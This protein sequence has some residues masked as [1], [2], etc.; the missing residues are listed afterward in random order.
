MSEANL[1]V[2]AAAVGHETRDADVNKLAIFGLVLAAM[3]LFGFV[4]TEAL[5]RYSIHAGNEHRHTSPFENARQIPPKP[6]LLVS[7]P[8]DYQ[9][10]MEHQTEMLNSY[11][12]VDPQQGTVRIPIDRAMHLLLQKGLP[13]RQPGQKTPGVSAPFEIPRGDF[14]PP[15]V[16]VKGPQQQ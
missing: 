14:G 8:A 2:G 1:P 12:W 5:F 16:G 6:H 13:T 7:D 9:H 15:P 11:G 4:V 3:I 10:Y